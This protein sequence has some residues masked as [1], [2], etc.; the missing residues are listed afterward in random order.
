MLSQL[1][2]ITVILLLNIFLLSCIQK[3][4]HSD[5]II[6]NEDN[7][8]EIAKNTFENIISK[9]VIPQKVIQ[10]NNFVRVLSSPKSPALFH[11]S[12]QH[13]SARASNKPINII[14]IGDSHTANDK[15]SGRL[16]QLF[17]RKFGLAGRGMLPVGEPFTYFRPTNV[18]VRQSHGWQVSNSYKR[19]ANGPYGL[20][21]FRIQSNNPN[22]SITLK[23]T[24]GTE[25]NEIDFEFQRTPKTGTIVVEIDG[26][27]VREIATIANT[28]YVDRKTISIAGGGRRVKIYPKGDGYIKL[29][30]WNFKRNKGGVIYHSHGIVGATVNVMNN[31]NPKLVLWEIKHLNPSLI[32]VAYG[33][34]EGFNDKLNIK[35]YKSVFRYQLSLLRRAAPDASIVIVGPPDANRLPRFCK[36]K[37]TSCS[38]LTSY[39]INNYVELLRHKNQQLCRWHPPAMLKRV[40]EIQKQ[41]AAE[42]GYLFWDWS[43]VM[44]GACGTHAWSQQKPRLAFKD[45]VHLTK[46]GYQISADTLFSVITNN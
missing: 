8:N 16:R 37:K 28:S 12:S 5:Q 2:Y 44:G 25:F 20:S 23:M 40:R 36:N 43:T 14:H 39:E 1:R 33:T 26:K 42:E 24:D 10:E 9:Q 38:P 45:H 7:N 29:L 34:N 35:K 31:W 46:R 15:F 18:K 6:Y 22:H 21:G 13:L 17:Q 30:S 11:N 19:P 27:Q 4:T 3:T 41:V 32:I